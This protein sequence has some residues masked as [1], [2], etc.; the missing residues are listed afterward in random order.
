MARNWVSIK[1][2][3]KDIGD[4]YAPERLPSTMEWEEGSPSV[5]LPFGA[6]KWTETVTV[7]DADIVPE[8]IKEWVN[9]LWVTWTYNPIVTNLSVSITWDSEMTEDTNTIYNMVLT[10]SWTIWA[11]NVAVVVTLPTNIDY[12]SSVDWVNSWQSITWTIWD[13]VWNYTRQFTI[14]SN[15]IAAWYN[16]TAVLTT[17]TNNEWTE[18]WS[19]TI[20]V[21]SWGWWPIIWCPDPDAS[22]YTE[23]ADESSVDNRNMCEYNW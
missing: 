17:D 14:S 6:T 7:R 22:N 1:D 5:T 13:L 10:M 3:I 23:W 2:K 19:K 4:E 16:I 12:V 9:I 21:V 15:D 20:D 8:K 11:E 18:T